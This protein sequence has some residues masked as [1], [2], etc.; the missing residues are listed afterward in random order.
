MK[1][2]VIIGAGLG[3]LPAAYK[4]RRELPK[5]VQITVVNAA[6]DFEFVPSL[7][8]VALG[9]RSAHQVSLPLQDLL[10]RRAIQ[11]ICG[12]VTA[13][14]PTANRIEVDD[15]S[16]TLDYDYLIITTGARLAFDEVPGL[17]PHG[18]YTQ[19]ICTLSQAE[20]AAA[21]YKAFLRDPGP[22]VIGGVQ[23]VSCFGPAYE[24]ACMLDTDLRKRR[25]RHKVPITFV[26]SEP[27]IGHLGLAGVGDSKGFFEHELRSRGIRWIENARVTGIED[28][29]LH[30]QQVDQAANPVREH[31]IEFRYGMLMP[32]FKGD[33][34][35]A[36]VDGLC[37][38]RGFV[39]VDAQQRSVK[40]PNIYALGVAIAIPPVEATPI[41]TGTPKTGYMIDSMVA[42]T[43]E[44]I[45]QA[46]AGQTPS[47]AASWNALCMADLGDSGAFFMAVPQLPPR[48]VTKMLRGRWVHW[49]KI[50]YEKHFMRK[51]RAGIA[52]SRL[53]RLVFKLL[54][55]QHLTG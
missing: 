51:M 12:R 47:H 43:V 19:S 50:A 10:A 52:E 14:Q 22:M 6:A 32:A 55:T 27:Y 11:F 40:Y 7:P 49:G 35:I 37:N 31:N 4:L 39:L 33:P 46:L 24:Y 36:A 28:G 42:A 44:N 34:A 18:G 15:G 13:L 48:N 26:T 41:P 29:V 3:G 53:E 23:G 1:H 45:K 54:G 17:G 8:W 5:D 30:A 2:I 9:W 21:S 16:L 38:P 25:L 20:Q